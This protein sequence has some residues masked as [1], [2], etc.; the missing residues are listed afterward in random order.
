MALG[1]IDLIDRMGASRPIMRFLTIYCAFGFLV[2]LASNVWSISTWTETR[3]V[4]DDVCYLRQAHLFQRFGLGGIDTDIARDDDL[5]FANKQKEIGYPNWNRPESAVCHTAMPTLNKRVIQY[6]PGTGFVLSLFPAGFQVIPLYVLA[7]LVAVVFSFLAMSRA[8]TIYTLTLVAAFG[9]SAIYLMI[10]PTKA[11]YSMA[12]T[13]MVCALAGYLTARLFSVRMERHKL[14]LTAS[15]GLL[16]GISA[17]FRLPNIFLSA[18]YCIF[19]LG[20]FVIARNRETL[21]QGLAFGVALLVGMVP[22]LA[23][24]AINAGSPFATTYS[25]IDVLPP[26]LDAS[27]LLSYLS[28]LQFL[29]LAIAA[30]WAAC[31][32]RGNYRSGAG[33]LVAAN[34]AVNIIF[35]MTHPI[36]TPYY[37]VPVSTLSLWTLLFATLKPYGETAADKSVLQQPVKV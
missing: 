1:I 37:T 7:S 14:F 16:L 5:W 2:L 6:P 8:A 28:D 19:L 27:V 15:I 3:G 23:A 36:F 18:G 12:P 4:Y 22:T 30:A 20:G 34:L 25:A 29:L 11:S 24:N 33:L 31:L 21:L 32:L 13:M 10:N 9:D 26:E 35:F 17:S